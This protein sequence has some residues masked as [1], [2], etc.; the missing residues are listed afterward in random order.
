MLPFEAA[1]TDGSVRKGTGAR[2]SDENSLAQRTQRASNTAEEDLELAK[3]FEDFLRSWDDA[4]CTVESSRL[5]VF[6]D[7][8]VLDV[9]AP[10][11][12]RA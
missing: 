9:L 7:G 2:L 3:A 12:R 11:F 4:V 1:L 10:L 6:V 8:T 5:A